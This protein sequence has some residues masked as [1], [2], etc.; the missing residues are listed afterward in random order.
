MQIPPEP[1]TPH[2][3]LR[4]LTANAYTGLHA[5]PCRLAHRRHQTDHE[6]ARGNGPRGHQEAGRVHP[7]APHRQ[8]Q[9]GARPPQVPGQWIHPV[10]APLLRMLTRPAEGEALPPGQDGQDARY[11]LR[12][13]GRSGW[14]TA[15][16]VSKTRGNLD[17]SR[18][19]ITPGSRPAWVRCQRMPL[20]L[21]RLASLDHV[22]WIVDEPTV[23]SRIRPAR[24]EGKNET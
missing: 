15:V 18:R 19:M 2:R 16:A 13:P 23:H 17:R 4:K 22:P 3:C 7:Q 24:G 9:V 11:L 8:R 12:V 6:H 1:Q 10:T 14:H 20:E 21:S 5:E